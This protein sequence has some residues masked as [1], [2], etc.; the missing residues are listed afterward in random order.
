MQITGPETDKKMHSVDVRKNNEK[1][2]KSKKRRRNMYV[3][4]S[5]KMKSTK[6]KEATPPIFVGNLDDAEDG[7]GGSGWQRETLRF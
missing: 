2:G 3:L 5:N 6:S 1:T 4:N 7:V